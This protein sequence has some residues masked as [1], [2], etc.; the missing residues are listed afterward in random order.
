MTGPANSF[1]FEQVMFPNQAKQF[2]RINK[3]RDL[4]G[5]N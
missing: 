3:K 4:N 5:C 2:I 1:S